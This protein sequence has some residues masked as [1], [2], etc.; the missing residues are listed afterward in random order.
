[1]VGQ[2]LN[3]TF[4]IVSYSKTKLHETMYRENNSALAENGLGVV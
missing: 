2:L 1:M 3:N 4:F